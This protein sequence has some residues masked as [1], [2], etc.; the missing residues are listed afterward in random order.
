MFLSGNC[1]ATTRRRIG[2]SGSRL[3]S[4]FLMLSLVGIK[5]VAEEQAVAA[6]YALQAPGPRPSRSNGPKV[7][8][9]VAMTIGRGAVELLG[10]ARP[11]QGQCRPRSDLRDRQGDAGHL[12]DHRPCAPSHFGG[13]YRHWHDGP[14]ASSRRPDPA[15]PHRK[16]AR[17]SVSMAEAAA[18]CA[19]AK[20]QQRKMPKRVGLVQPWPRVILAEDNVMTRPT[21]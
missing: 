9:R 8:S 2:V 14:C 7:I 16:G 4:S 5:V 13:R 15:R 12:C 6:P 18:D 20:S 19:L 17:I 3:P 1:C 10:L 21:E 11:K